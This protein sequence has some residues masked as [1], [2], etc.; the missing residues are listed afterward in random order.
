[1]Q[2]ARV[3]LGRAVWRGPKDRRGRGGGAG[4]WLAG[5]GGG[6]AG[7]AGPGRA[8]FRVPGPAGKLSRRG[9]PLPGWRRGAELRFTCPPYQ[10]RQRRGWGAGRR[11]AARTGSRPPPPRPTRGWAGTTP[12][13]LSPQ[14][15]L[16]ALAERGA[17]RSREASRAPLRELRGGCGGSQGRVLLAAAPGTSR[18]PRRRRRS[19]GDRKPSRRPERPPLALRAVPDEGWPRVTPDPSW[20]WAAALALGHPHLSP[21]DPPL[22]PQL[23]REGRGA[24]ALAGQEHLLLSP[25]AGRVMPGEAAYCCGPA[26]EGVVLP[27]GAER[28]RRE[29]PPCSNESAHSAAAR[30]MITRRAG[31][32]DAGRGRGRRVRRPRGPGV[33]ACLAANRTLSAVTEA[34]GSRRPSPAP[35]TRRVTRKHGAAPLPRPP[36][37]RSRLPPPA[38]HFLPPARLLQF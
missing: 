17:A 4:P 14:L 2:S 24:A 21:E 20:T 28:V 3:P 31:G 35:A 34:G 19:H 22:A 37:P 18:P 10:R 6:G 25:A 13:P 5:G 36:S 33:P 12:Q 9:R 11:A 26:G 8:R 29:K 32:G 7:S 1:M 15:R 23:G 27:A 30:R 38:S 16:P